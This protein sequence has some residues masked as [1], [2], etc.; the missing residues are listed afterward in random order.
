MSCGTRPKARPMQSWR[1][2]VGCTM[3][4]SKSASADE[5]PN[6][7]LNSDKVY[8]HVPGAVEGQ[9]RAADLAQRRPRVEVQEEAPPRRQ[10]QLRVGLNHDQRPGCLLLFV[11]AEFGRDFLQGRAGLLL[12]GGAVLLGADRGEQ[13][14]LQRLQQ[15]QLPGVG[16]PLQLE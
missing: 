14:I 8:L 4:G 5:E 7:K 12:C 16:P 3:F 13:A 9:D 2:L 6:E 11:R 15:G 1:S 10:D